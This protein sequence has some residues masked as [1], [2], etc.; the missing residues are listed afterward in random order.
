MS[1]GPDDVRDVFRFTAPTDS[2][3][4]GPT[5]D[6]LFQFDRSTGPT[7]ATSDKIDGRSTPPGTPATRRSASSP[8]S[9]RPDRASRPAR[10]GWSISAPTCG[11]RST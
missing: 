10:C 4:T 7:D 11:S 1:A 2:G 5:M 9:P 8:P 6:R 3:K